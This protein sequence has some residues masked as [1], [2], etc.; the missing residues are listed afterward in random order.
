MTILVVMI[1]LLLM[2]GLVLGI[3]GIRVAIKSRFLDVNAIIWLA[4]G[5][6]LFQ[7]AALL[8]KLL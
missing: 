7:I 1:S 6:I 8:A 3:N 4:A 2:V 5:N